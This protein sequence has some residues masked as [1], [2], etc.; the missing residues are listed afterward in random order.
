MIKFSNLSKYLGKNGLHKSAGVVLKSN[1]EEIEIIPINSQWR[2]AA[3]KINIPINDFVS[4]VKYLKENMH[5]CLPVAGTDDIKYSE[6]E[7]ELCYTNYIELFNK[8]LI[9]DYTSFRDYMISLRGAKVMRPSKDKS[10]IY[11][12]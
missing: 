8:R 1:E 9:T 3:C 4:F 10:P 11:Y 7:M 6:D 5:K 2:P 12:K